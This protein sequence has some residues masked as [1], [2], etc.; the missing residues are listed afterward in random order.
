MMACSRILGSAAWILIHL[1]I[2]PLFLELTG[3]CRLTVCHFSAQSL[4][5]ILIQKSTTSDRCTACFGSI[6]SNVE[7]KK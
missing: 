2:H 6:L 3:M 5:S 7:Y 4:T 1:L